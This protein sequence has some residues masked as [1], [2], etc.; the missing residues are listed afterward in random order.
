MNMWEW[1]GLGTLK[2]INS[3]TSLVLQMME[4][5]V[6]SFDTMLYL[7]Y[8][9]CAQTLVQPLKFFGGTLRVWR[10]VLVSSLLAVVVA[11][12][13]SIVFFQTEVRDISPDTARDSAKYKCDS[14]GYATEWP[15]K[16][17]FSLV[18]IFYFIIPASVMMYCYANIIRMVWLKAG[19]VAAIERSR[20]LVFKMCYKTFERK[21]S[22]P[23]HR[24]RICCCNTH[25]D[26]RYCV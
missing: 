24:S 12:P 4:V 2:T 3:C 23:V 17:Y 16:L 19:P 8:V 18:V 15:R 25:H 9:T 21:Q 22:L 1:N 26:K 7:L 6:I 5:S 11:I 14:A 10:C 20:K 13:Q